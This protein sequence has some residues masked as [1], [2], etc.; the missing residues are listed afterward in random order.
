MILLTLRIEE[1]V[2]TE[3]R[4]CMQVKQLCDAVFGIDNEF[5]RKMIRRADNGELDQHWG[6]NKGKKRVT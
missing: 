3:L 2:W 4:N 5:M 1:D 6:F